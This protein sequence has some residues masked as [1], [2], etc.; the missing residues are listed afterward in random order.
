MTRTHTEL[1]LP[2]EQEASRA[3]IARGTHGIGLRCRLVT[4]AAS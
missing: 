1:T 2:S 4:P 3:L